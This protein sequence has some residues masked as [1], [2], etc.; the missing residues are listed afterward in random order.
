MDDLDDDD[1]R[2][3][4]EFWTAH[5]I[6]EHIRQ[7]AYARGGAP[8]AVL[9]CVLARV[10]AALDYRVELPPILGSPKPLNYLVAIVGPSGTGKGIAH[11]IAV[12]LIDVAPNLTYKTD[13]KPLG[14]GQGLVDLFFDNVEI[15][16]P[17][18]KAKNVKRQAYNN[19]YYIADEGQVLEAFGKQQGSILMPVLRTIWSGGDPGQSNATAERT[20]SL[21][22]GSYV[23]SGTFLFVPEALR[24]LL[25]DVAGGTPQRF[26]YASSVDASIPDD[27]PDW[28]GQ[29]D[30]LSTGIT[31][32][33]WQVDHAHASRFKTDDPQHH[34][35]RIQV[36]PAIQHEIHA[37]YIAKQR[38]GDDHDPLL[39][40]SDL[41]RE[42]Q[43]GILGALLSKRLEVTNELWALAGML[44]E[45]SWVT[46]IRQ[47][48]LAA[49]ERMQREHNTSKRLARRKV[50][51]VEAIERR[52]I[53]KTAEL[54][55][56]HVTAAGSAGITPSEASRR[57]RSDRRPDF[58]DGLKHATDEGWVYLDTSDGRL[59]RC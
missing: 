18:G 41:L 12:D 51:E 54:I 14:S 56:S 13:L 10:A 42:K 49:Q 38:G 45:L 37:R 23:A 35:Y 15:E 20:R 17:N 39:A 7:A 5:P 31:Y 11:D 59:H 6:L 29:L 52:N 28:P 48:E 4:E 3:P 44:S 9:H 55:R 19:A 53:V 33:S 24:H 47:Q 16:G 8:T 50:D 27:P 25:D 36:S 46:A 34:R 43:A 1:D 58:D 57:L 30:W 32:S 22:K 26:A 2:L 21:P 40:Q